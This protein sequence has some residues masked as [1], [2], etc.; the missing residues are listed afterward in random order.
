MSIG[1]G[2]KKNN[3][4]EFGIPVGLKTINLDE[5]GILNLNFMRNQKLSSEVFIPFRR[6]GKI[7]FVPK[8][9]KVCGYK[10][11]SCNKSS[12]IFLEV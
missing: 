12:L 9:E 5:F 7:V 11:T 4:D 1:V 10:D 6:K 2:L 8:L 3:I